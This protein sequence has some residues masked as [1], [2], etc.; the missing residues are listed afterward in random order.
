MPHL[1]RCVALLLLCAVSAGCGL[2]DIRPDPI[3]SLSTIDEARASKGRALIAQMQQ[4][5]GGLEAWQAKGNAQVQWEDQWPSFLVRTFGMPWDEEPAQLR[6]TMI[7]GRDT[8]RLEFLNGDDKG[9]AWGIQQWSTYTVG[10]K[11]LPKFEQDDDITFWLPT[12]QYFFEAAYRLHEGQYIAHSGTAKRGG[13]TYELVYITWGG[14]EPQERVDQYVAWIDQKTKRLAYLQFTVRDL[15]GFVTSAAMYD[16][17]TSVDGLLVPTQV[18]IVGDL[19]DPT[20]VVHRLVVK[21]AKLGVDL[22]PSFL[23]PDPTKRSRK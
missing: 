21:D 14:V 12:M 22:P 2:A 18:T 10:P 13:K 7:L 6:Q 15:F 9:K 8:S 17:Y 3:A 23:M 1:S 11:T 5:H 19:D 4:A 20:D 16:D